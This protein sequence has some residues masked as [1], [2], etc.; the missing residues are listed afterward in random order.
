MGLQMQGMESKLKQGVPAL[1]RLT[2]IFVAIL[3]RPQQPHSTSSVSTNL[4]HMTHLAHT[5]MLLKA[6]LTSGLRLQ[7]ALGTPAG[8]GGGHRTGLL[9]AGQVVPPPGGAAGGLR[10]C[11]Q[12]AHGALRRGAA[13]CPRGAYSYPYFTISIAH[14]KRQIEPCPSSCMAA[15]E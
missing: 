14:L 10:F 15:L 5:S 1:P 13:G 3:F 2:L 7:A 8:P 4:L 12:R 6:L 9:H 11:G